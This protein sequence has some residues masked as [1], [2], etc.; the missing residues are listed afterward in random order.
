MVCSELL[1]TAVPVWFDDDAAARKSGVP[2]IDGVA[3]SVALYSS[4]GCGC[5]PV[6]MLSGGLIDR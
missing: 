6:G 4:T 1:E 2:A 5:T 3:T